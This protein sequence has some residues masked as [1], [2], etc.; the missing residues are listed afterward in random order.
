VINVSPA[1]LTQGYD[2][3]KTQTEKLIETTAHASPDERVALL[4]DVNNYSRIQ[5]N[6]QKIHEKMKQIGLVKQ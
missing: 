5:Q 1:D 4:V 2:W 3:L 6:L